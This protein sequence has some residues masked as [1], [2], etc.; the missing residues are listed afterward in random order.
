MVHRQ[1]Q[2]ST[3]A[4]GK[5]PLQ[6]PSTQTPNAIIKHS[7]KDYHTVLKR[8]RESLRDGNNVLKSS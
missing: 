3:N 8:L 7:E 4:S 1:Q 6:Q 2:I 5:T